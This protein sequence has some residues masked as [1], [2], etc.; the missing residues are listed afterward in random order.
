[1][2]LWPRSRQEEEVKLDSFTDAGDQLFRKILLGILYIATF[3]T[4]IYIVRDNFFDEPR[5]NHYVPESISLSLFLI[6]I[7]VVHKTNHYK[8]AAAV[9]LT[10]G[11]ALIV[12]MD[13]IYEDEEEGKG[14]RFG[15]VVIPSR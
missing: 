6:L 10:L 9:L 5:W 13:N 3:I 15:Y 14:D 2:R 12:F 4:V 11:S 7:Y 1:M 8:I